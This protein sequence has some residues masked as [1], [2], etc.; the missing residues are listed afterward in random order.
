MTND[1][2]G[3]VSAEESDDPMDYYEEYSEWLI[4]HYPERIHNRDSLVAALEDGYG[5][6]EFLQWRKG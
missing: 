5:F 4:R 3:G 2:G 1:K 6:E